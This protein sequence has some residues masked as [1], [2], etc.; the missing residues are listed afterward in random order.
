[1]SKK[2]LALTLALAMLLTL[3][4]ACGGKPDSSSGNSS[5]LFR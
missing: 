1:M 3:L 5:R 2:L 4:G